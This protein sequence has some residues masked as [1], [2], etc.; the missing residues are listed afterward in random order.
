V[1]R[2]QTTVDRALSPV[3]HLTPLMPGDAFENARAFAS[4]EV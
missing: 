1:H 4:L 2:A 3:A